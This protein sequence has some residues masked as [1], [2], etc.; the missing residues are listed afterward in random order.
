MLKSLAIAL[1]IGVAFGGGAMAQTVRK[2]IVA[3]DHV[4]PLLVDHK[5]KHKDKHWKHFGQRRDDEDENEGRR[6]RSTAR[7]WPG[8]SNPYGNYYGSSRPYYDAPRGYGSYGYG[9]PRYQDY[10]AS[11]YYRGY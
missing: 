3:D 1:A 11:P 8:Y 5:E 2:P 4:A 7:S 6:R 10:G 9:P